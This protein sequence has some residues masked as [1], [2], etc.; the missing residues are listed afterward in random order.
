MTQIP[1]DTII[2]QLTDL[3]EG[4]NELAKGTKYDDLSD[5]EDATLQQW[6]T[7]SL[8]AVTRICPDSTY[9]LEAQRIHKRGNILGTKLLLL[10][11]VLE[12]LRED[13]RA[14]YLVS[15]AEL[16]HADLFT[17]F[18]EMAEHLC[19]SG[20]KDAAAVVCGT[21]LESH[22]RHLCHKKGIDTVHTTSK[23]PRPVKADKMNS[24]LAGARVYSKLDQKSVT[25]WL[26]LRNKAA[27]GEYTEYS[28]D[29]VV[30]LMNGVRD[31]MA[32][33]PA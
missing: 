30:L 22:L 16:I 20:Y 33:H 31:F 8:A 14:G 24:D 28:V 4:I 2:R 5:R 25:A 29:Q 12:A 15:L 26:D 21:A 7:R 23:G 27:H 32:R 13:V 1:E 19:G 18:I 3:I 6:L 9:A 11:G 10:R 17:D